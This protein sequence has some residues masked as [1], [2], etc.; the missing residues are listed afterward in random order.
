MKKFK[1]DYTNTFY[2]LNDDTSI[3]NKICYSKDFL[4]WKKNGRIQL[5]KEV[6]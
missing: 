1:M 3:K 5:K 6:I 2:F 4:E